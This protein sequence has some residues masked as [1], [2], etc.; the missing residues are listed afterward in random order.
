ME[1]GVYVFLSF[2]AFYFC[3]VRSY[4]CINVIGMLV[5]RCDRMECDTMK[6]IVY[7]HRFVR[8]GIRNEGLTFLTPCGEATVTLF[9]TE[10]LAM[11]L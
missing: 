3:R 2:Y 1:L 4:F 10:H 7:H 5:D 9:L 8:T 6:T 11:Y